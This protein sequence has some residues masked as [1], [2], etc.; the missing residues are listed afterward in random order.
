MG[1]DSEVINSNVK[2]NQINRNYKQTGRTK[3]FGVKSLKISNR[4]CEEIFK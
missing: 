2:F 4:T 1:L 3:H